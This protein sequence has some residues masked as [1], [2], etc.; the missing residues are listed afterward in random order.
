M[1]DIAASDVTYVITDQQKADSSYMKTVLTVA[2]G[3]GVLTYPAGGIPLTAGKMGC[4]N[5]ITVGSITSPASANGFVYKY[6]QAN[7]K[8][9]IYQ[10]P[11]VVDLDPAAP[12]D[13]LVAAT[14]TPAATTVYME[15]V[16]W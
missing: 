16:G 13:E 15:V 12:L 2:F 3:D 6:D 10:V 7:N 5:T 11:A 4:P 1:A 9:R 8:I 14:D